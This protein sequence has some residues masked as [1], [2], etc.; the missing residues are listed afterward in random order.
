MWI[1][2]ARAAEH[3][4]PDLSGLWG[5]EDRLAAGQCLRVALHTPVYC[6]FHRWIRKGLWEAVAVRR[7][8]AEGMQ[9]S[10]RN[11]LHFSCYFYCMSWIKRIG[12]R[13]CWKRNEHWAWGTAGV[14]L[15]YTSFTC[16]PIYGSVGMWRGK[17]VYSFNI[18]CEQNPYRIHIG[19]WEQRKKDVCLCQ[20]VITLSARF[21]YTMI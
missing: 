4:K 15:T 12:W 10:V 2:L 11:F 6:A 7:V 21:V 13:V 5:P 14:F 19:M 17:K 20:C 16:H 3:L 1:A 8:W 18:S 9:V